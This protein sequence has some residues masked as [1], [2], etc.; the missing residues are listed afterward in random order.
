MWVSFLFFFWHI[1]LPGWEIFF[2]HAYGK[3]TGKS[4]LTKS[5][6]SSAAQHGCLTSRNP[7]SATVHISEKWGGM[8][9]QKFQI[10]QHGKTV[11]RLVNDSGLLLH[12]RKAHEI[13]ACKKQWGADILGLSHTL[14]A[15]SQS[16]KPSYAKHK[17]N[18]WGWPN[19][20]FS[21]MS[22]ENQLCLG[23]V[24]IWDRVPAGRIDSS[25]WGFRII[26]KIKSSCWVIFRRPLQTEDKRWVWFE[27][28]RCWGL[29]SYG[30]REGER[31]A[32]GLSCIK[33]QEESKRSDRDCVTD[34][35]SDHLLFIGPGISTS[36]STWSECLNYD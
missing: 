29:Y 35:G 23:L 13:Q 6:S 36:S 18:L 1:F 24:I 31:Q 19:H 2:Y 30:A 5:V 10:R 17:G 11:H 9:R 4:P 32:E 16:R 34:R 7:A 21:Y 15:Q 20:S 28:D 8:L 22:K 26:T 27:Q 3:P 12:F 25:S 14:Q 33:A